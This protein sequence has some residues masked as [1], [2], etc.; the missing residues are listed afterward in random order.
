MST[1]EELLAAALSYAAVG[2]RVVPLHYPTGDGCSCLSERGV[3]ERCHDQGKH[4][5]VKGG[6]RAGTTDADRI[7]RWWAKRAWNVGICTGDGLLV[8]DIDPRH[9]GDIGLEWIEAKHGRLPVC[10]EALTG[11][12]GRHLFFRYDP[13]SGRVPCSA[14]KLGAGVDVRADGGLVVAPP[15]VHECGRVYGWELSGDPAE[16]DVEDAPPWL[17]ALCRASSRAGEREG[18]RAARPP[19]REYSGGEA[20]AEGGRHDGLWLLACSWRARG[21]DD[22][23]LRAALVEAN[24]T[25][26][27]PPLER[28]EVEAIAAKAAKYEPGLSP[29]YEA[30]RRAGERSAELS[31]RKGVR[32]GSWSASDP[33]PVDPDAAPVLR[34]APTLRVVPVEGEARES[35]E[36]P[37]AALPRGGGLGAGSE[38]VGELRSLKAQLA[39]AFLADLL[40]DLA[41]DRDDWERTLTRGKKN[42]LE[43]TLGNAFLIMRNDRRVLKHRPR[44]NELTLYAEVGDQIV[45]DTAL[46]ALRTKIERHWGI[47]PAKDATAD[48]LRLAAEIDAYNPVTEYL[49]ALRWDGVPRLDRIA[50]EWFGADTGE[51]LYRRFVLCFFLG[52]V[53]RAFNPG[54]NHASVLV[55]VGGQGIGKSQFFRVLGGPFFNESRIEVGEKDGAIKTHAAW[56]HEVPEVESLTLF[57]EAHAAK[58]FLTL[59]RDLFRPPYG[60]TTVNVPR[61]SIFVATTNQTDFLRDESGTGSRRWHPIF[62]RRRIPW[63][64]VEALR[65]QLWAEAVARWRAGESSRLTFEEEAR[66]EVLARDFQQ[67]DEWENAVTRW[68]ATASEVAWFPS[69]GRHGVSSLDL[70]VCALGHRKGDVGLGES[71]RL[72]GIMARLGWEHTKQ[73]F[74]V[75]TGAL[76]RLGAP[77]NGYLAPVGWKRTDGATVPAELS[78]DDRDM[79][80][81]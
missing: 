32:V 35:G 37:R 78:D 67:L 38:S 69:L 63:E 25:R 42:A 31:E 66:R 39:R 29:K 27:T 11:G 61:S 57:R 46:T 3:D 73:R 47:S 1:R 52:A 5:A 26:C 45:T 64:E 56:I 74:P 40:G 30:Q 51:D 6:A 48:A 50:S 12:R 10:V 20:I 21:L 77:E 28:A 49:C 44:F 75:G 58:S 43:S 62:V 71:R 81:A 53:N 7:R 68:A 2:W 70:H 4:P 33:V 72:G 23:E 17:L 15:S 55:L 59:E 24:A 34:E 18:A 14:G 54:C 16:A 22:D 36:H 76:R 13:A 79:P 60:R 19:K 9:A 8:V 65:D 80:P 41:L